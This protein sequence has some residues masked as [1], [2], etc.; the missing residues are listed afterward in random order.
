MFGFIYA[1]IG[2]N[3]L[4]RG[5]FLKGRQDS[6]QTKPH[7]RNTGS[8]EVKKTSALPFLLI[9]ECSSAYLEDPAEMENR[10]TTV[11]T[12]FQV[13]QRRSGTEKSTENETTS[14]VHFCAAPRGYKTVTDGR[15]SLCC[16]NKAMGR[17]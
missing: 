4:T 13:Q 3:G 1:V 8:Q 9:P 2:R 11:T 6:Q 10:T 15:I 17:Q 14:L 12:P 7:N 5:K 16:P